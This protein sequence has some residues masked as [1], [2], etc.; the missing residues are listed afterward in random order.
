MNEYLHR[1]DLKPGNIKNPPSE[2]LQSFSFDSKTNMIDT[3]GRGAEMPGVY[4][5]ENL[6]ALFVRQLKFNTLDL[7]TG[8]L[9]W[10]FTGKLGGFTISISKDTIWVFQRFYDS[11]GLNTWQSKKLQVPRHPEKIWLLN[12]IRYSGEIKNITVSIDHKM[13]LKIVING[14]KVTEQVCLQDFLKHQLR[15]AGEKATIYGKVLRPE[16]Q[17]TQ[18]TIDWSDKRQQ[19]LGFGGIAIPTAYALFGEKGKKMWWDYLQEYNLLL[20]REYPNGQKLNRDF[21]N[22]DNLEDATV[23]YYGDNFPN[24]EISNFEYIRKVQE[25]GGKNIFEFWK[26]PPWVKPTKKVLNIEAYCEAIINYC[27]KATAE[28]GHPPAIVGIQ[29]EK[30]MGEEKAHNMTLALRKALDENEFQAVK[31]HQ[32]DMGKLSNGLISARA[33]TSDKK[34]WETIDFAASHMYDFQSYFHNPDGYDSLLS[35]FKQIIGDKPFLSTELCVNRPIFQINSYRIAFTM[36]QL[37]H[38]NLTITDA[39]GIMY[40]W[41]L[42]NNIQSSYDASRSLFGVDETNGFI[43]YP[44][45]YQLRT[46]G[47]FS[48]R[49]QE[50]M[51]RVIAG[52]DNKDI[53]VTAF[54]G[55]QGKTIVL[56]NRSQVPQKCELPLQEGSFKY[57][58]TTSPY[59]QNQI[60]E[61]SIGTKTNMELT[62]AP[63]EVITLSSVE[64]INN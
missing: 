26:F 3:W 21:D 37:Y 17:K 10:L 14:I 39:C 4:C 32:Q 61:I 11:Y 47:S 29:N 42:L 53:L 48:R 16:V 20:H 24:S 55:E 40:C 58:E 63:G 18:I 54:S 15:F 1:V 5:K 23:H 50:G 35:V 28:T 33:F 19:M 27:K 51:N 60:E 57:M 59:Y 8:R 2:V 36:A 64:L 52:S 6:P 44:S 25:L 45:G 41:T 12:T 34:V 7:A 38:K 43:P 31:I 22:W 56:V 62:I 30:W 9:E 49:V 46:F 13:I